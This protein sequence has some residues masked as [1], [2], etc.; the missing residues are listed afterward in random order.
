MGQLKEKIKKSID[1]L[2]NLP[3]KWS[4]DWADTTGSSKLPLLF[5]ISLLFDEDDDDDDDE[6]IGDEDADV[7][8]DDDA[9]DEDNK[10][11]L[12]MLLSLDCSLWWLWPPFVSCW[13]FVVVVEPFV[14]LAFVMVVLLL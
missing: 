8:V 6:I 1:Y 7:D 11:L 3:S 13:L 10:S 2:Q 12:L 9:D 14:N 4:P 5:K